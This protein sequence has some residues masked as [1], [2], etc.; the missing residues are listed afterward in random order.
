ML[1]D[2]VIL[3]AGQG[4]RMRS[5]KPKVLHQLA[6]KSMLE[7]VVDTATR[8]NPHAIHVIVGHNSEMIKQEL[9]HLNVNWVKQDMQL[10]TGHAVMQALPYLSEDSQVLILSADVPLI[11]LE[12][13]YGLIASTTASAAK[14]LGLLVA[15]VEDPFGFGRVVRDGAERIHAIIE[16]KDASDNQ[17]KINEIYSGICVAHSK[18]LQRWLPKLSNKNAQKEYYLTEIIAKASQEGVEIASMKASDPLEILGV[19][20]RIQLQWLERA[21]QKRLAEQLMLQGVRIMDAARI[22]IRG[23]LECGLDVCIDVNSVFEGSVFIGEGSIIG[24]NC[25]LKN[26]NIGE[27]CEILANSVLDNCQIGDHC[28][29]GPFARIRPGTILASNCKI[30]NFVEAKNAVMDEGS[31]ANHLSYLGDVTIGKKVN[32]GAGTITC[33]YD[34]A[35]K[36]QTIIEDG[37]FIGSDTQ[38]VAPVTVGKNATIGAGSTIRK[39]APPGELTLSESRQKTISG[40]KRPVKES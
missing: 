17:R 2:I 18:A 38:L 22:D 36:Y 20:D 14:E 31:K 16:E 39:N 37:A 21:F 13:L 4:K 24:P 3:A 40:W 8:L 25:V 5:K 12:T 6:G 9:S 33:N 30:G 19:N 34:G 35:N 11:Q 27:H 10:G 29:I 32:I 1:L 26:V 15:C 28:Q 7:R 23:V